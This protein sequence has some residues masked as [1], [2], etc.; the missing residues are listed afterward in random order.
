MEDEPKT[1][2][3][4]M[5]RVDRI[6]VRHFGVGADDL[7]DWGYHD[8]YEDGLT[9]SECFQTMQEEGCFE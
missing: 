6:I 5:K 3:A 4:W 2:E 8:A 9:P 1:F 7:P